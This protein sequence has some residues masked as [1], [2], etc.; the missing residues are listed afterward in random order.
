MFICVF[1]VDIRKE[2]WTIF[3]S[4]FSNPYLFNKHTYALY[5]YAKFYKKICSLA[6]KQK[7][8][9]HHKS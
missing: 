2:N 8:Q 9:Q 7:Q 1:T 4:S 6:K 3:I 5:K